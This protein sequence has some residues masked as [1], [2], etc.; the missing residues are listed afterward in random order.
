VSGPAAPV[1]PAPDA[2]SPADA[3]PTGPDAAGNACAL[4]PSECQGYGAAR[5]CEPDPGTGRLVWHVT[6]CPDG[7]ACLD[8]ACVDHCGDECTLGATQGAE[9]CGLFDLPTRGEVPPGDGLHDRARLYE[10]WAQKW[11]LPAGR[12]AT[13]YFTD[14]TLASFSSWNQVGDSALWT[15]D[16]LAA[17]ALRALAVPSTEAQARIR[18]LLQAVHEN[19]IVSGDPGYLARFAAQ[20]SSGSDVLAAFGTLPANEIHQDGSVG[21]VP[22]TW[23]GH[24]SRDQYQGVLL[25]YAL[26]YEATADESLKEIIRADV[27]T[28][29]KELMKDRQL[30]P[31]INGIPC[32]IPISAR[33]VVLTSHEPLQISL[34]GSN[35]QLSGLQEFMP[36]LLGLVPRASSAI[37]LA[38][39][40]QVALRVTD[41]VPAYAS[42]RAAISAHY[43]QNVSDWLNVANGW[44]ENTPCGSGYSAVDISFQPMYNLARLDTDPARGAQIRGTILRDRMW[45][46]VANHKNVFFDYIYAANA[47]AGTDLAA[48]IAGAAAQL[49]QFPAPP[50]RHVA[51]NLSYPE[52]PNCPGN[53]QMAIDVGERKV[54][55]FIWQRDPWEMRDPGYPGQVFPGVDYLLAYWMGRRHGFLVEDSPGRCTRWLPQ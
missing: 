54:D 51:R 13:T 5:S 3:A 11:A 1:T 53:A 30:C 39:F 22:Y 20:N 18:A 37:M 35:A 33:Y 28:F 7:A 21:G 29:V 48:I 32:L 10:A 41:G 17:E 12:V 2:A 43:I 19:W 8:G 45:S 15:G 40:F 6:P 46:A 44:N 16:L 42:D 47:P 31:T 26:A 14:D 38:S 25:G 24:V 23:A 52:D 34:N 36:V 50:R 55:D 9:R 27:V 4:G 49:A